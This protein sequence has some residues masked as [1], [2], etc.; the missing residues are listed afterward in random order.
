MLTKQAQEDIYNTYYNQGV[1]LA[2]GQ[3][4]EAGVAK[5][6]IK[7][8][9]QLPVAGGGAI[10]GMLGTTPIIAGLADAGKLPL[11]DSQALKALASYLTAAGTG[12]GAVGAYK[13]TGKVVDLADAGIQKLLKKMKK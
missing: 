3:I 2:L 11:D 6:T 12:A 10:L 8:M 4:K 13:G 9:L 5:E 1:E 7:K